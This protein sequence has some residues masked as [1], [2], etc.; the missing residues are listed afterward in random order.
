MSLGPVVRDGDGSANIKVHALAEGLDQLSDRGAI[1]GDLDLSP[2][3]ELSVDDREGLTALGVEIRRHV[4]GKRSA[5]TAERPV[6]FVGLVGVD[7]VRTFDGVSCEMGHD[8]QFIVPG[9]ANGSDLL[10][11]PDVAGRAGALRHSVC[12]G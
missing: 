2:V 1:E 4:F 10:D 5:A 11:E 7:A 8:E 9:W 6:L 3:A 12:W